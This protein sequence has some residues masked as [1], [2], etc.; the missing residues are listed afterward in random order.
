MEAVVF[1]LVQ[2]AAHHRFALK[3]DKLIIGF[4]YHQTLTEMPR[5]CLKLNC[6][7]LKGLKYV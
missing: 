7:I 1:L 5:L 3:K 2:L 4:V 6:S